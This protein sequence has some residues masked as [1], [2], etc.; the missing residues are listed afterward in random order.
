MAAPEVLEAPAHWRTLDFISDLHLQTSQPAT[1]AAWQDFMQ[2]SP[3]D[4]IFILGD[5]FE[6]WVGDDLLDAGPDAFEAR[7]A[8]VLQAAAQR[9]ALFFLHGNRDFLIGAGFSKACGLTLLPDPCTLDMGGQRWLLSHGD[10]L[11][12]AD[13]DYLQ[14]RAQVRAP[15]W[16]QHFLQQPLAQRLVIARQLRNQSKTHQQSLGDYA[17]VD[18][19]G[20]CDWLRAAQASTLLHGHTHRPGAHDLGHGMRRIVLSDWDLDAM[21]ARAEVL[22]LHLP[23]PGS[24][25]AIKLER[26]AWT[27]RD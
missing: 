24:Q 23:A 20:A 15:A 25:A 21:P 2:R 17:D 18:A 6:A 12:L 10:A 16:Q 11:C 8:Q 4:A 13:R 22:R 3:A 14:F 1:F 5:L 9:L 26:L 7:C 19:A 27:V